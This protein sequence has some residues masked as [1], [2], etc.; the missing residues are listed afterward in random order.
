MNEIEHSSDQHPDRD[1]HL[2]AEFW[3]VV[4]RSLELRPT[5]SQLCE[6]LGPTARLAR[7]HAD[8]DIALA[9]EAGSVVLATI[10]YGALH[11]DASSFGAGEFDDIVWVY[12]LERDQKTE[13]IL[14]FLIGD[15]SAIVEK[16]VPAELFLAA[17]LGSGG[18]YIELPE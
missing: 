8:E 3:E 5:L 16:T 2:V 12:S 11:G 13:E 1:R 17:W 9:V 10:N 7:G 6:I 14:A 4:S 15:S 18:G